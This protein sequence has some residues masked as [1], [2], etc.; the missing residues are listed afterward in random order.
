MV[1]EPGEVGEMGEM[2]HLG[3]GA[4]AKYQ[5]VQL[6]F[7]YIHISFFLDSTV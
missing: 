5:L 4:A 2:E 1:T 3:E 7:S 6:Q